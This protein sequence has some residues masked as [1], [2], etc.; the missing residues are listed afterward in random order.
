MEAG[1][2]RG[3]SLVIIDNELRCARRARD[4]TVSWHAAEKKIDFL[5]KM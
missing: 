4:V 2:A 3:K 5:L 1:R